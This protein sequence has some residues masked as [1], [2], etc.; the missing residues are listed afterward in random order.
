MISETDQS[1]NSSPGAAPSE[2]SFSAIDDSY[3]RLISG[4]GAIAKINSPTKR[5]FCLDIFAPFWGLPRAEARRL[6]E[7]WLIE[8]LQDGGVG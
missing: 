8:Q 4:F 2:L 7:M 5:R 3:N 1:F 6:F